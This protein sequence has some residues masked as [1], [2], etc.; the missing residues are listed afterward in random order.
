MPSEITIENIQIATSK[1]AV[2]H[3][4]SWDDTEVE[5]G[6]FEFGAVDVVTINGLRVNYTYDMVNCAYS[7]QINNNDIDGTANYYECTNPVILINNNGQLMMRDVCINVDT[8]GSP[9]NVSDGN[10]TYD[11]FAFE[12]DGAVIKNY[13]VLS[14][15]NITLQVCCSIVFS[16][17]FNVLCSCCR[18]TCLQH[19]I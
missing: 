12:H 16:E 9:D 14:V 15:S 17:I 1:T 10:V 2:P 4:T 3:N 6:L 5:H 8:I 7:Y 19:I 11:R 13:G 18:F